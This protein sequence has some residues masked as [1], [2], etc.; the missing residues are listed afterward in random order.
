MKICNVD[1]QR[2]DLGIAGAKLLVPGD[3][4]KSL[5]S[6]RPHALPGANRMPPRASSLVDT[7]GVGVIDD[8]V[9]SVT[10]CP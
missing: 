4:S 6:V 2:G 10:A 8:W 1:P 9:R 3:P 5:V 7:K